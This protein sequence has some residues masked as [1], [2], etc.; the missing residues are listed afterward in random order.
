MV[1]LL[2]FPHPSI[3]PGVW[4][5]TPDGSCY[6]ASFKVAEK[7]FGPK[8]DYTHT[9]KKQYWRKSDYCRSGDM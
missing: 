5:D 9:S 1:V 6:E 2:S 3:H 4:E 8:I 7:K